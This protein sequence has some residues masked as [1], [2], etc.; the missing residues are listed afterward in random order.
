MKLVMLIKMCLNGTC[1]KVRMSIYMSDAFLI[2]N[3]L[4]LGDA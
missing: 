4:E 2:R 3:F 1:S